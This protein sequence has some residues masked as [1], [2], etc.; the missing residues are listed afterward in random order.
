MRECAL[1]ELH[2]YLFM[3]VLFSVIPQRDVA[4]V[5]IT[6]ILALFQS[7][8]EF[9]KFPLPPTPFFFLLQR[10][11]SFISFSSFF[12]FVASP[13]CHQYFRGRPAELLSGLHPISRTL[14]SSINRL[15][16]PRV[17]HS[18]FASFFQSHLAFRNFMH[19]TATSTG[20]EYR[21]IK[22]CFG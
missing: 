17:H 8:G 15:F 3:C 4:P 7:K 16:Y 2:M 21:S 10:L 18:S 12:F 14:R 5:H 9:E 20:V 13:F 1:I 19:W 22:M 11:Y 6:H